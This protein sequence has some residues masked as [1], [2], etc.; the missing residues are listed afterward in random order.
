MDNFTRN[1]QIISLHFEGN[2][3]TT[4]GKKFALTRERVR[5]I[6]VKAGYKTQLAPRK[7]KPLKRSMTKV[8]YF[9]SKVDR[10]GD[11][12]CWPF[13]GNLAPNGYARLYWRGKRTYAFHVAYLLTHSKKHTGVLRLIC[14][15][16][17]CANPAHI[18]DGTMKEAIKDRRVNRLTPE[19]VHLVR[20]RYNA[21]E[22]TIKQ[23]SIEL[24]C[25]YETALRIARNRAWTG[26]RNGNTKLND[27]QIEYI[28]SSTGKSGHTLA[29]ELKVSPSLIQRVLKREGA[30]K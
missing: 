6:V 8:E 23:M 3:L 26:G 15:N 2:S 27:S 30:Y 19:L 1:Q 7:P 20:E 14:K 18:K 22:L 10:R 25:S 12:E 21:G 11:N 29:K 16:G 9:W 24:D 5:Q 17:A 28:R 13:N 4:I